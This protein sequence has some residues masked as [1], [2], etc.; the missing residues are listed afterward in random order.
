[1]YST[2]W[3]KISQHKHTGSGD[4]AQLVTGSYTDLSITSG[5]LA[6]NIALKQYASLMA[7][8]GTTQTVNWNNGNTQLLDLGSAS[9]NVTL[10]LSNPQT[11]G[12]YRLHVIQAASPLELVWPATLKW[13]QGVAPI[14]SS[15][16]DAIDVIE[17][18]W[19][20]T[21]YF[22]VWELDFS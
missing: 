1:M 15:T 20:G 19:D 14:L 12:R 9:G 4:G 8:V 16:N 3:T 21:N 5:K 7:P 6:A 18:Y 11:G 2:T 17:L 10:T 13:P 22:G